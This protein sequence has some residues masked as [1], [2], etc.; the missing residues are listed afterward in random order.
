MTRELSTL[1]AD[2]RKSRSQ[3]IDAVQHRRS[4]G[5]VSAEDYEKFVA[6][7][8]LKFSTPALKTATEI[9]QLGCVFENLTVKGFDKNKWGQTVA[10]CTCA[11][12]NTSSPTISA[13]ASGQAKSCGCRRLA[14]DFTEKR[15][16]ASVRTT[17]KAR[18][19]QIGLSFDLDHHQVK[20]LIV[21][22]CF[23]CGTA[24]YRA[25]S[26]VTKSGSITLKCNGIDRV[27]NE[28]G[29][30]NENVVSCCP[31]C[32]YA[33]RDMDLAEFSAWALRLAAHLQRHVVSVAS[34]K[35]G[36]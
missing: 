1:T 19:K 22:D 10:I 7:V 6:D 16:V 21:S 29:Y 3:L 17:Y 8:D 31:R 11:C 23:Y 33:K 36:N 26:I 25:W 27:N 2:Q 13:L 20:Q 15:I 14:R 9:V 35:A 18:A 32:N 12:G 4:R 34:Q 24:P 5:T 30:T 28:L